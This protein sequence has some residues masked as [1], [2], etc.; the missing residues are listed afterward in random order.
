MK[1][2]EAFDRLSFVNARLLSFYPTV[3]DQAHL[4]VCGI[5]TTTFA[6]NSLSSQPPPP[7]LATVLS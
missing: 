1:D 6:R 4:S 5:T 7:L 2:L 3:P